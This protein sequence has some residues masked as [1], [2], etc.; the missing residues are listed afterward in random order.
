MQDIARMVREPRRGG[1]MGLRSRRETRD[2]Y[3]FTAPWSIGFLFLSFI[4]LIIGLLTSFTNYNGLNLED[5]KFTALRNYSRSF[6]SADFYT[7]LKNTF[8][9]ALVVV[10]VGNLLAIILASMLN[11]AMAGRA[12]FRAI[13]YLPSIL[14]LAGAIQAWGLMFNANAGAVNAFISLFLP[15]TA[16]NWVNQHF[17]LMLI[18]FTWW[19]LGGAM[20]IYLAGLQGVPEEL[21]EAAT[22]DGANP[23][24]IFRNVTL[25][26]LT[27]VIFFQA[28][29]GIVGALQILDSAILL[30]GRTG[31]SGTISIPGDLYMYMVYVYSQVFDFQRYGYGVALSWIFFVIVLLL[32][33]ILLFTSRYWVYYEVAQERGNVK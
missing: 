29:L 27:P 9:Y 16:I 33:I 13:Y 31:L 28:I 22:M 24:Q 6:E 10:P 5:I 4:P 23:L 8:T 3:L 11:R 15:G 2:F 17:V 12:L 1:K 18:L 21:R 26:L 7:S 20:I 14:P 19:Q 32:T 25:P 30:Y